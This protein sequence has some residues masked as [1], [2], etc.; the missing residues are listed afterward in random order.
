MFRSKFE[1][2]AGGTGMGEISDPASVA[3]SRLRHFL[4]ASLLLVALTAVG[5]TAGCRQG[6]GPAGG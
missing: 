1:F 3:G 2:H 5:L 4:V 6:D